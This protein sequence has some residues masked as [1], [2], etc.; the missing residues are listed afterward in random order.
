MT[1]TTTPVRVGGSCAWRTSGGG[2]AVGTVWATGPQ[3][4]QWWVLPAS[5]TSLVL[6]VRIGGHL[7]A[8]PGLPDNWASQVVR[9]TDQIRATPSSYGLTAA[10]RVHLLGCVIEPADIFD[11]QPVAAPLGPILD[12]VTDPGRHGDVCPCVWR[13]AAR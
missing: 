9:V 1:T 2:T 3:E 11:S 8:A 13:N 5:S 6:V 10:N 4:G 7:T 12:I